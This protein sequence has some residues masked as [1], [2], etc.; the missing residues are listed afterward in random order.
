MDSSLVEKTNMPCS[1]WKDNL[2]KLITMI[3][4][5]SE[6]KTKD[7]D[8]L[9]MEE[10]FRRFYLGRKGSVLLLCILDVKSQPKERFEYHKL[11]LQAMR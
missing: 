9:R 10:A 6:S 8:T 3:R 5:W 2:M 7:K 1:T 11:R 4:D